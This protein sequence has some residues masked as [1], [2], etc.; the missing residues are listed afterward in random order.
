MRATAQAVLTGTLLLGPAV[1]E[2]PTQKPLSAIGSGFKELF[3]ADTTHAYLEHADRFPFRHDARR[4]EL[5]NAWWLAEA[6]LL[7][8][9]TP[10]FAK[11]ALENAGMDNFLTFE[12]D[13]GTFCFVAH[14]EQF[15]IV[16]FRGTEPDDA[17]D[18]RIDLKLIKVASGHGGKIHRGFKKALDG[19]W[20][21][22]HKYLGENLTTQSLWFTG[23]SLGAALA[24]IAADRYPRTRAVYNFGSPRVGNAAFKLDYRPR[25]FRF[26]NTNDVITRAPA[27]SLGYDHVGSL[28]Y[29]DADG[30]I[31]ID[32]ASEV[33]KTSGVIGARSHAPILY[34]LKIWNALVEEDRVTRLPTL[35]Y[36]DIESLKG[37]IPRQTEHYEIAE[38]VRI[39]GPFYLFDVEADHGAYQV[40]S[41]ADLAKL[42]H[43]I[44]AIEEYRRSPVGEQVW[45]GAKEVLL[46]V[47]S[48]AKAILTKPKASAK[49]IG[50]TIGRQA[51]AVGRLFKKPEDD[52][53]EGASDDAAGYVLS[54]PQARK[55]AFE[56]QVDPYSE[57]PYL[58]ALLTS[59]AQAETAG[60]L[61]GGAA[62][63]F[64][65]PVPG[66]GYAAAGAMTPGA[67]ETA[68]E[69]LIR[70]Y[71]AK[72]LRFQ[73]KKNY[74]QNLG[75]DKSEDAVQVM[76]FRAFLDNRSFT[77]REAAYASLY[78]TNLQDVKGQRET[79]RHLESIDEVAYASFIVGQL[80]LYN[81]AHVGNLPLAELVPFGDQLAART[82]DDS[83]LLLSPYDIAQPSPLMTAERENI[84][85]LGD[86]MQL[87]NRTLWITGDVADRFSVSSGE[88]GLVARGDLLGQPGFSAE[89]STP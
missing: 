17:K 76:E 85:N 33:W 48:G 73:L 40:K 87:E 10:E 39:D 74:I 41:S 15:A 32:P 29:M 28:R 81:A 86:Q 47:G 21:E 68:T 4:F 80:E 5:V 23:H 38:E 34:V 56:L 83:L 46:E 62:V 1:A 65:A 61:G 24:T 25:L 52:G 82:V 72:E 11:A 37:R 84:N 89:T 77:P 45:E 55:L 64:V 49:A 63:G 78:L 7:A 69:L 79:V 58:R 27:K 36:V 44:R 3:S 13:R 20:P 12:D 19:I 42:C 54:E 75:L 30:R 70:D 14:N 9:T 18:L 88:Q 57:N 2:E 71:S 59:V 26:V 8:Y 67:Y 35:P 6:S 43:E 51:R 53:E 22:L 66:V 16:A 60:R 50:R 31:L